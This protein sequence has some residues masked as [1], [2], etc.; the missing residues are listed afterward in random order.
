MTKAWHYGIPRSLSSLVLGFIEDLLESN[1]YDAIIIC[2]VT[3]KKKF[4]PFDM[5]HIWLQKTK[6]SIHDMDIL[7]L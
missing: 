1:V 6:T 2:T 5:I 4:F 7:C 3:E